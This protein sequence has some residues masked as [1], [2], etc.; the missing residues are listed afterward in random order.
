MALRATAAVFALGLAGTANAYCPVSGNT[1]YEYIDKVTLGDTIVHSGD[2]GGYGDYSEPA[3]ELYNTSVPIALEAGY[4][5]GQY[6]EEWG[7]WIDLDQSGTL[8]SKERVYQGS[9]VG[10][11]V[12]TLN[13]PTGT[14]AGETALRVI[15]NY[16]SAVTDPC[17]S[18]NWG[19]IEDY[20]ITIPDSSDEASTPWETPW[21]DNAPATLRTGM[22]WPYVMGYH[23]TPRVDGQVTALGG[24]FA[25]SKLVRLFHRT[26]GAILAEV[27]VTAV[28][29]WTY[30]DLPTPVDVPAGETYTVAVYLDGS[31]GGLPL[32][33]RDDAPADLR[34]CADR[35]DHLRPYR[36]LRGHVDPPDQL[37]IDRHVRRCGH[38]L[39]SGQCHERALVHGLRDRF[40]RH[41][42]AEWRNHDGTDR[43]HRAPL[44]RLGARGRSG[45][46]ERPNFSM[47]PTRRL[48]QHMLSPAYPAT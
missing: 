28:N 18:P 44:Q 33:S 37:R 7:V 9:G 20:T 32:P 42:G 46:P 23:F 27:T 47:S 11:V 24:L 15:M 25:G 2:D 26:S 8:T 5:S 43:G 4:R 39:Q 13:I 34:K 6:T 29:G 21:R 35:R 38:S 12:G 31:G 36:F 41:S 22:A 1:G 45:R 19:E 17:V 48:R 14:P 16:R 10:T 40:G 3:V 30:A